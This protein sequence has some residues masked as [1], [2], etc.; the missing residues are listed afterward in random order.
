[1]QNLRSLS[2]PYFLSDPLLPEW[3]ATHDEHSTQTT[4][5]YPPPA[6]LIFAVQATAPPGLDGALPDNI[7]VP[8]DGL[9][10]TH[11]YFPAIREAC[12]TLREACPMLE[13]ISWCVPS[14]CYDPQVAVIGPF[15]LKVIA[16]QYQ[17]YV[18]EE[19]SMVGEDMV[20]DSVMD[21]DDPP[22]YG[23]WAVGERWRSDSDSELAY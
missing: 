18:E 1:M 2:L 9:V 15:A 4:F 6:E 5:Y 14:A 12:E 10:P 13:N 21:S 20:E 16:W 23:V 22:Q 7:P 17:S 11:V 19:R 8:G 3:H